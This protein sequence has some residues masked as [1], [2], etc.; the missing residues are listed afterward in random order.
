MSNDPSTPRT[1]LR[2]CPLCEAT[3]GLS[4]TI[5]GTRVTAARGDR[6]DVFSHG[7]VCPKGASIGG[8]DADPDRLRTRS[9]AGTAP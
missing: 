2:I 1:A 9:S 6:A 8:L 3:C 4:L 7:F 5:E